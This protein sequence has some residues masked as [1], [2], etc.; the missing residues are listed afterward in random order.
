MYSIHIKKKAEKQLAAL[1]LNVANRIVAVIDGLA[2]N[3]RPASN[4][5]LQGYT[6]VYRIRIGNY[7]II[8]SVEDAILM[9]EVIKIGHRQ[10][11]YRRL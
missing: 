10:S 8:Y 5:K 3:P 11:V 2:T 7:R 9:I 6:N 4:T 1:P